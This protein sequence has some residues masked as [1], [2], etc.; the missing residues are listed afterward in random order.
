V[1]GAK[2][3]PSIKIASNTEIAAHM[4]EDIDYDC[5]AVLSGAKSLA[6]CGQDLFELILETASG[7]KSASEK[8]GFGDLEFVPWQLGMTL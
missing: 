4:N 2:P 1:F 8:G 5:G 6:E 3:A 7:K